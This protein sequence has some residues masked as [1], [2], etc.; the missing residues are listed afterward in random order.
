VPENAEIV[1]N[2]YQTYDVLGRATLR[3]P[4]G[5]Q[6]KLYQF[7]R[8]EPHIVIERSPD[9]HAAVIARIK[10]ILASLNTLPVGHTLAPPLDPHRRMR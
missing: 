9:I 1:L 10:D 8:S 6:G 4:A 2:Y 7:A 5:F 3:P